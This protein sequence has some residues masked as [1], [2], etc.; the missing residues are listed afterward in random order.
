MSPGPPHCDTSADGVH[1]AHFDTEPVWDYL[2]Q[3]APEEEL[4]E[5][6]WLRELA[7]EAEGGRIAFRCVAES[8]ENLKDEIERLTATIDCL[9]QTLDKW[10]PNLTEDY[11]ETLGVRIIKK[12]P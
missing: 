8:N 1:Y 9:H 3:I 2:D 7:A 10:R 11:L 5:H 6:T 12:E 4:L